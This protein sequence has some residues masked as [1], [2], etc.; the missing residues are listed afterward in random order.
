MDDAT[1]LGIRQERRRDRTGRR[2]AVARVDPNDSPRRSVHQEDYTMTQS[3]HQPELASSRR[4]GRK[5]R[6]GGFK[7]HPELDGLED[8]TL[9]SLI[10]TSTAV[11]ASTPAAVYGQ[12]V[13]VTATVLPDPPSSG[14]PTGTVTFHYGSRMLGTAALSQGTASLT[15]PLTAVG[16]QTITASYSGD[17]IFAASATGTATT[18]AGNGTAGYS[19]DGGP[20]TDAELYTPLGVAA[21]SA[22]NLF[23]A[24]SHNNRIREVVRAT[25]QILT[26]AGDGTAG[27]NG[28]GG[29]A[30]SA[31][32]NT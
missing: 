29:P 21:D 9:L 24:D 25:G 17:T 19:G 13:T 20:A 6:P 23:F 26:V 30:T 27:Y 1:N 22:G 4:P 18:V 3:N 15:A 14:T 16:R 28:D 31:A 10:P 7:F 8:R 2:E 32:L 11:V 12:A 5:P